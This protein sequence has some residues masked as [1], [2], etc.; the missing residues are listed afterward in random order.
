MS[1]T[2]SGGHCCSFSLSLLRSQLLWTNELSGLFSCTPSLIFL[3][4]QIRFQKIPQEKYFL[5]KS[6]SFSVTRKYPSPQLNKK[7]KQPSDLSELFSSDLQAHRMRWPSSCP[8]RTKWSSA[9]G[10]CRSQP[11][12]K[13]CWPSWAQRAQSQTAPRACSLSSTQMGGPPATLLCYSL[14]RS[15]PRTLSKSTNRSW[16]SATSSCLEV[17]LPKCNRYIWKHKYVKLGIY[18]FYS[19]THSLKWV[20]NRTLI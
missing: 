17:R 2:G 3:N 16:G 8:R 12:P 14:V 13:M 5:L 11:R 1:V 15:T 6:S 20:C 19:V 4:W 18:S 7:N 9:C 10:A